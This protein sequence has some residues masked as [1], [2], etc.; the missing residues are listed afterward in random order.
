M[1]SHIPRSVRWAVVVAIIGAVAVAVFQSWRAEAGAGYVPD[2]W[3][4][5]QF[6]PLGPA[7]RDLLAKV[8]QAG[9]WE[10]PTGQ[11][12]Q[13][14]GSSQRVREVGAKI[15][16]EHAELDGITRDAAA[17][18]DVLLPSQPSEEQQGW[19]DEISASS[20]SDFDQTA[21]YLLRAAHGKVLPLISQV[22]AGTRNDLGRTFAVTAATFVNRHHE[23]LES[24]GLVDY[25]ALPEPQLPGGPPVAPGIN[26]TGASLATTV[27]SA[28]VVFFVAVLGIVGVLSLLRRGR[29]PPPEV[30]HIPEPRQPLALT[31][32]TPERR[33]RHAA[34]RW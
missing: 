26:Q 32:G 33:P 19:M 18:L 3:V 11:E 9:L 30:V 27:G 34:R 17:K 15:A 23:Y 16:A 12:V 24:T 7:D 29:T 5:T 22:R 1:L 6:G 10:G 2:G 14:R 31:A 25:S 13:Q 8:R 4:D 28:A 20:G 21:I